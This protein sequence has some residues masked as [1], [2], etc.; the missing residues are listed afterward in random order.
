MRRSLPKRCNRLRTPTIPTWFLKATATGLL[1]MSTDSAFGCSRSG[2]IT[3]AFQRYHELATA[4]EE[5]P[6]LDESDYSEREYEATLENIPIAGWRLQ[7][8]YE[9]PDDWV[10][11]VYSW[12]SDNDQSAIENTDDQ[13]G[14]PTEEQLAEAFTALGFPRIHRRRH[15]MRTARRVR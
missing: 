2:E 10:G 15:L 11:Q 14:W 1:G 6:I 13:G 8:E 12:F 7:N 9:L 3:P 4:M 5:Y